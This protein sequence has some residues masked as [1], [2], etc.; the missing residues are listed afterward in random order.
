MLEEKMWVTTIFKLWVAYLPLYAGSF[1]LVPLYLIFCADSFI[2]ADKLKLFNFASCSNK[3]HACDA[4][5]EWEWS[6]RDR[7]DALH[8]WG[9]CVYLLHLK[10]S[11]Q[12]AE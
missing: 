7:A 12:E 10:Q 9:C 3:S 2:E 4:R 1:L 11:S 6:V 5:S 8:A